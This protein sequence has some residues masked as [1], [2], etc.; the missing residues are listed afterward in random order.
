M[1]N[2]ALQCGQKEAG[3]PRRHLCFKWVEPCEDYFLPPDGLKKTLQILCFVD[4]ASLYNL[5]N[6]TKLVHNL[7]SAYLSI[8]ACFRWLWDHHQEKQLCLSDTCDC[9]VGKVVWNSTVPT[10]QSSTQNNKYQVSHKHCCFS[11]WW[12]HSHP[13]HVEID[14]YN[15]NKLCTKLVLFTRLSNSCRWFENLQFPNLGINPFLPGRQN[16]SAKTA[17]NASEYCLVRCQFSKQSSILA[18]T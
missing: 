17:I 5:V 14:K 3:S 6:K 18:A 2:V 16:R 11:W 10:R 12:A 1:P 9:L 15:K 8:S 13:K 7:F 4:R